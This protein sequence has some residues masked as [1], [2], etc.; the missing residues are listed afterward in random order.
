MSDLLSIIPSSLLNTSNPNPDDFQ[1]Q[2]SPTNNVL[3]KLKIVFSL[4]VVV[5]YPCNFSVA[6]GGVGLCLP[7]G[8]VVL[9]FL[10]NFVSEDLSG[11]AHL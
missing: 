7:L 6:K 3:S 1:S 10:L 5:T 9:L 8:T 11:A 4:A 2:F